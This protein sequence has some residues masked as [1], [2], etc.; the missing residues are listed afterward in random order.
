MEIIEGL[1]CLQAETS[2]YKNHIF[3]KWELSSR[4]IIEILNF[5][6]RKTSR[7]YIFFKGKLPGTKYRNPK[8]SSRGNFQEHNFLPGELSRAWKP[9]IM[10]KV[11]EPEHQC[12]V[13]SSTRG[14]FSFQ[15]PCGFNIN[16]GLDSVRHWN[17]S[18]RSQIT[19]WILSKS[20]SESPWKTYRHNIR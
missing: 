20:L 1:E 7:N 18:T 10:G 19:A 16:K 14:I 11:F 5:L 6:Q 13:S 12:P 4:E 2:N 15:T 3:F 17:L 9:P 8:F